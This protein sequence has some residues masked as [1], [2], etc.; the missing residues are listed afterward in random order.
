MKKLY[1]DATESLNTRVYY[2]RSVEDPIILM[3]SVKLFVHPHRQSSR[4]S[5]FLY[6]KLASA[7][8]CAL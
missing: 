5:E 2:V 1:I 8:N 7:R 3:F 4:E 6:L